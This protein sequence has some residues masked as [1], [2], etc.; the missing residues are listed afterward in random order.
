M[1]ALLCFPLDLPAEVTL[2][3]QSAGLTHRAVGGP[4]AVGDGAGQTSG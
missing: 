1:D 4:E 3:L 2:A